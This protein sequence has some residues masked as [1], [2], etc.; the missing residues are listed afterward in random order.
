[1]PVK[2]GN[3]WCECIVRNLHEA[4]MSL[5]R[6]LDMNQF[7]QNR[8]QNCIALREKWRPR[9]MANGCILNSVESTVHCF[10][11]CESWVGKGRNGDRLKEMGQT[12]THKTLSFR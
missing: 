8:Q 4:K 1:M 7:E 3:Q 6:R 9:R 10:T 11:V 5:Q 2:L 12:Y